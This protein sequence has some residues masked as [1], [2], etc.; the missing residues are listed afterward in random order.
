VA[1]CPKCGADLPPGARFCPRD[2]ATIATENPTAVG[3][4]AVDK[5]V[6]VGRIIDGR[7]RVIK[8]LGAGGVGAVYEGEHV[9]IKKHVAI[10]VLHGVFAWTEEFR[11]RFEREARAASRLDH[12]SCVSV[13]DFG[14]VQKLD[15]VTPGGGVELMGIPYLVME[16]VRGQSLVERLDS[17]LSTAEAV[18]VELGILA[19]LKH[20]HSLDIIHRDVKPA[21]V[22]LIPD[23]GKLR[24][25]LLDFGLAKNLGEDTRDLT[26]AGTV[27]GTPSYLSPEQAEGKKADARSDLYAA[28]VVLF[29]MVCGRRPFVHENPLD[30]VRDHVETPPPRPRSLAPAISDELEQVMLRALAKDPN[31][32][33]QTADAFIAALGACPDGSRPQVRSFRLPRRVL[34]AALAGAAALFL[35]VLGVRWLAA[36]PAPPSPLPVAPPVASA[37]LSRDALAHLSLAG[38]YQRKLWCSDAIEELER[39]LKSDPGAR[40]QTIPIAVAC[41]TPKTREK[42]IRFL[43]ERVGAEARPILEQAEASDEN[44]EVRKGAERALARLSETHPPL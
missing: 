14:K 39:A 35:L 16:F 12:P 33:Y 3:K 4:A 5:G 40:S 23:E 42:A 13:L 36:R 25:K 24:A 27:F 2:G 44:P 41:L 29:E 8:K 34:P 26:Q 6:L 11:I 20:A 10:K 1:A 7:Y 28:G 15:P 32:R 38:D 19:A 22:M 21:N 37:T 9:E 30:I 31:A 17:G 43:V 18:Q